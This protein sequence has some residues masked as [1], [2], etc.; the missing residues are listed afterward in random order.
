MFKEQGQIADKVMAA[1]HRNV[2]SKLNKFMDTITAWFM[3]ERKVTNTA[4]NATIGK[5]RVDIAMTMDNKLRVIR[6]T[7]DKKLAKAASLFQCNM[8][9]MIADSAN[10]FDAS[11]NT[12]NEDLAM[13]KDVTN[14]VGELAETIA[15]VDGDVSA[16]R[17]LHATTLESGLMDL[18]TQVGNFANTVARLDGDIASIRNLVTNATSPSANANAARGP[19]LCPGST[20]NHSGPTQAPL[21]LQ[22]RVDMMDGADG[23][24]LSTFHGL[25]PR[26]G[27]QPL[28]MLTMDGTAPAPMPATPNNGADPAPP[29]APPEPPVDNT[30][31]PRQGADE[32]TTGLSGGSDNHPPP[33]PLAMQPR[34]LAVTRCGHRATST[35][36]TTGV[37]PREYPELPRHT[38]GQLH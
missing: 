12:I 18:K 1:F 31:T 16:L 4:F 36:H 32:A 11:I 26:T 5:A 13:V 15:R 8:E 29:P 34:G 19:L 2:I 23:R 7:F 37:E 30:T 24:P 38:H 17:S 27:I 3:E 33:P 28:R 22:D 14:Q 21:S 25:P 20:V 35:Y 10:W 6:K 9:E